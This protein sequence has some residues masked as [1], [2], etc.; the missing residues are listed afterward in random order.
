[1]HEASKNVSVPSLLSRIGRIGLLRVIFALLLAPLRVPRHG[2]ADLSEVLC[3]GVSGVI[4][5]QV[6]IILQT[7]SNRPNFSCLTVSN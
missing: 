4:R 3:D 7:F 6:F 1:M 2:L 5:L